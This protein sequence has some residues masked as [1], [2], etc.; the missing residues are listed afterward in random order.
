MQWYVS[1]TKKQ[2]I[3]HLY[4]FL[5]RINQNNYFPIVKWQLITLSVLLHTVAFSQQLNG[6]WE[7]TLTQ[8]A[9]GCFPVYNVELQVNIINNK[10]AGF[11]YHYSDVLNYVK[12]NYNGFY[13]AATK[14]ID[15]QEEKVTTFHIPSDCTPCIR[16]FSLAYSNSGNKEI[17]SG[18]WG[19]VVMNGT[20]PCTPGKITLHR[21]AQ[22]DFNHIQEIK[23]DTG[24]I[25]L[26]FYD[27]AEIDGDSITVTL[28]NRPL[29]SHQKLGLK[30]LTLE[31]KVDLDHREQ[32]ITMIADNLG[33]IPPNTAMVII[34]AADRKYRLFLKSDKQRSAQ[35]RVVYEDPRLASSN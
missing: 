28:D 21:V 23:V 6:V 13:N 35:V 2:V 5:Y 16:Y 18:E 31:V 33:T 25:R 34:T 14:T 12:K 9:G 10:V 15:I 27:N 19:G 24:M 7:G 1:G 32:E 8:Q 29:L 11:C 3:D 20:A 17:L 4:N 22:S 26:D 30:P